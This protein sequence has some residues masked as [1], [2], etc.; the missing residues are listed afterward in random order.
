MVSLEK[1]SIEKMAQYDIV[2]F[3][4]GIHAG[5]INGIKFIKNNISLSAEYIQTVWGI[6]FKM[7]E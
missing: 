7:G 5:R 2:I 1:F 6:G 4:G 3:G